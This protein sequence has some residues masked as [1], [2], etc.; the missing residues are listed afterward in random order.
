MAVVGCTHGALD[1]IYDSVAQLELENNYT[2]DAVLCCGDFQAIR[3]SYDLETIVT[4]N[5][6][7]KY[8]DFWAYYAGHKVAPKLTIFIGGNH[9]AIAHSRELYYGG[10]AAPNIYFLGYSGVVNLG[11]VRIGGFSGIYD[12]KFFKI[13]HFE[14]TPYSKNQLC[15]AMYVRLFELWKLAH[16]T[17]GKLDTIM[18]HDWPEYIAFFGNTASL[19]HNNPGFKESVEKDDLG[20]EAYLALLRHLRPQHWFSGHMHTKFIAAVPH[21]PPST[22]PATHINFVDML[23]DHQPVDKTPGAAQKALNAAATSTKFLAL[24]KPISGRQFLDVVH[25]PFA[26]GE[27]E[28]EPQ[29]DINGE[30]QALAPRLSYDLEF[31]AIIRASHEHFPILAG[32]VKLPPRIQEKELAAHRAWIVKELMDGNEFNQ[33]ALTIKRSSFIRSAA[34]HMDGVDEEPIRVGPGVGPQAALFLDWLKLDH[35]TL[36][37]R[38]AVTKPKPANQPK[39]AKPNPAASSSQ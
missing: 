22:T 12:P 39:P 25:F 18:S 6:Y 1:L 3:N 19:L 35:A 16:L 34:T 20:C 14:L 9:E 27:R 36:E 32:G 7:R 5:K 21:S 26:S 33:E 28:Q 10:W 8:V 23:S 38:G 37:Q 30:P 31:L 2:I 29:L 13:G 11:G 15:S 4:P 17:P 24:D